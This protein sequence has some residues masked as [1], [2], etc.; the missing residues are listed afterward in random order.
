MCVRADGKYY[1]D[2]SAYAD[3]G[4]HFVDKIEAQTSWQYRR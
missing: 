3:S 1:T 2:D 4:S